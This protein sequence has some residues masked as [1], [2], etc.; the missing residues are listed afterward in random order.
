VSKLSRNKVMRRRSRTRS[1]RRKYQ[2]WDRAHALRLWTL[3]VRHGAYDDTGQRVGDYWQQ[4]A[5]GI[6]PVFYHIVDDD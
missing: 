3:T 4:T 6:V 1:R 5:D 2:A